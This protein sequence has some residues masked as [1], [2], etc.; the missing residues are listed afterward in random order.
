[1][2]DVRIYLT[3]CLIAIV[4]FMGLKCGENH[5]IRH[6]IIEK[7]ETGF[8]VNFDGNYYEYNN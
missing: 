7:T 8:L 1:M 6:Q 5:V 4:F 3:I 2:K